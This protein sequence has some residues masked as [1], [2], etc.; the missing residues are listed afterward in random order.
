MRNRWL[1]ALVFTVAGVAA[2]YVA[3]ASSE[4]TPTQAVVA[5]RSTCTSTATQ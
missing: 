5:Q 2:L 3:F 1:R 4:A